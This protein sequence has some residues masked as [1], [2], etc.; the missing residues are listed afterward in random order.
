[1]P[2]AFPNLSGALRGL[3]GTVRRQILSQFFF[4]REGRV[5]SAPP[6]AQIE[7]T[8][9]GALLVFAPL[10]ARHHPHNLDLDAVGVLP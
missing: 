8:D 2:C 10:L 9:N 1:M 4:R 7:R 6:L 5:R 3:G